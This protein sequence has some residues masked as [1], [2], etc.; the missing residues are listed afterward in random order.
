MIKKI[1]K[2]IVILTLF[3]MV[4]SAQ[5]TS[6]R[7]I[8]KDTVEAITFYDNLFLE[9]T[10]GSQMLF[11][12]DANNLDFTDRLTPQVSI[13]AGKWFSPVF[14]A[15]IKAEGFSLNGFST[16]EGEYTAAGDNSGIFD[17]DPVRK[18]VTI[19]SDGTYRHFIRYTN[20]SFNLCLSLTNMILGYSEGAYFDLVASAGVG[21]MYVFNYKGIPSKN[22]LSGNAGITLKF[23]LSPK[24]DLNVNGSATAFPNEFEGRIAGNSDFENYITANIG[25][26]YYF[27]SRRFIS[28]KAD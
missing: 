26:V 4:L 23:H 9:I 20:L 18:E 15:V 28:K 25:L 13:S 6:S 8:I 1:I 2:T 21:D 16:T 7:F 10:G 12:A 5:T 17:Q 11:S 27:K 22:S 19:N 14:G 3:S 24:W